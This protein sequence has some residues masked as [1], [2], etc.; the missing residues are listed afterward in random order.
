MHAVAAP[1]EH[2]EFARNAVADNPA[3]ALSLAAAIPAYTLAKGAGVLPT[4]PSTTPASLDQ[5]F[6]GFEGIAQG[7]RKRL[8]R[9]E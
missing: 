5:V 4:A 2:R 7:L 6:A 1:L 3:M 8:L 9:Q